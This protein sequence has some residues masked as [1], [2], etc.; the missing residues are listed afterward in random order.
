MIV[1]FPAMRGY[2]GQTP[3]DRTNRFTRRM[4]F[5]NLKIVQH[6]KHPWVVQ[7]QPLVAT[8][9]RTN[10]LFSAGIFRAPSRA[11]VQAFCLPLSRLKYLCPMS[12]RDHLN[13]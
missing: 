3:G 12:D 9:P 13:R 7:T 5:T 8:G 11:P 10:P 6:C 4:R 2:I 1:S